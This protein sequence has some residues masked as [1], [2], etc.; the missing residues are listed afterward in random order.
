[1]KNIIE[2]TNRGWIEI[3]YNKSWK[4]QIKKGDLVISTQMYMFDG[5]DDTCRVNITNLE[6]ID[7][8]KFQVI[9]TDGY[10][11]HCMPDEDDK[12]DEG[13]FEPEG[14]IFVKKREI[15]YI[16]I[17]IP[18]FMFDKAKQLVGARKIKEK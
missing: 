10:C 11:I 6:S 18:D 9:A 13:W 14:R 8:T 15:K 1:M 3:D 7:E 5:Y 16:T 2:L 12:E 17:E 4:N